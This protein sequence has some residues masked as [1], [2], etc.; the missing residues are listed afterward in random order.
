VP[1]RQ[2]RDCII[3]HP[4][5]IGCCVRPGGTA[6]HHSGQRL[7]GVIAVRQQGVM[8]EAFEIGLRRLFV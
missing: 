2:G 7:G 4:Q 1:R 5:V 3:E 8:A 6:A